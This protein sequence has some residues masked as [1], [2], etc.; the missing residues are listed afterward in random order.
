M[1]CG[2]IKNGV[3]RPCWD[4]RELR[5]GKITGNLQLPHNAD[6]ASAGPL[7]GWNFMTSFY[8]QI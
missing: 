6:K 7:I 8:F 2:D 5:L 4:R 1:D 3:E